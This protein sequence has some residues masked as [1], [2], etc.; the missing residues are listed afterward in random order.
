MAF[1]CS[2][3][4]VHIQSQTRN[5]R[6]RLAFDV[7]VECFAH[8]C[9]YCNP[10]EAVSSPPEC[11][12]RQLRPCKYH[13]PGQRGLGFVLRPLL[14]KLRSQRADNDW[15]VQV[16]LWGIVEKAAFV[17][18][19]F[20]KHDNI[21]KDHNVKNHIVPHASDRSNRLH[22]VSRIDS[23]SHDSVIGVTSFFMRIRV[24]TPQRIYF[25]RDMIHKSH[26]SVR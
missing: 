7:L 13:H 10:A 19:G 22:C 23:S 11:C 25:L 17:H 3:S 1:G 2:S 15:S 16:V 6:G 20:C 8:R 26:Q 18:E 12:F 9:K 5:N 14:I 21:V 24:S 4:A